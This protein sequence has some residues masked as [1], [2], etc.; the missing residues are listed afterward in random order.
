M[1]LD[2]IWC[3][4]WL[5]VCAHA[6][7]TVRGVEWTR[8]CTVTI[9]M[10]SRVRPAQTIWVKPEGSIEYSFLPCCL[11]L[12]IRQSL[13]MN[14]SNFHSLYVLLYCSVLNYLQR[15]PHK[16]RKRQTT[17]CGSWRSRSWSS[18]AVWESPATSW[19]STFT[20]RCRYQRQGRKGCTKHI[21][22]VARRES[23]RELSF[24]CVCE[25]TAYGGFLAFVVYES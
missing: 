8:R 3:A 11:N 9:K 13:S 22:K 17:P 12:P 10:F 16:S 7:I 25:N 5:D 18:T 24:G 14:L 15:W 2:M 19:P 1:M 21:R 6:S 23:R 20:N 4:S